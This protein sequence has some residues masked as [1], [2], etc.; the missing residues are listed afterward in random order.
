MEVVDAWKTWLTSGRR[1]LAVGRAAQPL[2]RGNV[3]KSWQLHLTVVT[4]LNVINSVGCNPRMM[5]DAWNL[6]DWKM[7]TWMY[8]PGE[9]TFGETLPTREQLLKEYFESRELCLGVD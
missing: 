9:T 2:H 5:Y 1:S 4:A 3:P 8:V 7:S 6:L